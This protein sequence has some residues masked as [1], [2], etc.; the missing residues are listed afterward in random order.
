[1]AEPDRW[2][3]VYARQPHLYTREPNALLAEVVRGLPPRTALDIG[4]GQ[5]RNATYLAGLGW[6]VTG[7]DASAE[8]VRQVGEGVRAIH[9]SIEEFDLGSEQWDLI[10]GMY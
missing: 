10:L 5:G 2:D 7:I 8:G 1:M 3:E 9:T 4:M 6:D